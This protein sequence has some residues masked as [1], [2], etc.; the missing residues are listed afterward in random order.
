MSQR[1]EWAEGET[2]PRD[3]PLTDGNSPFDLTSA[4]SLTLLLT[5]AA[6]DVAV[7]SPGT[8]AVE[9]DPEDGIVRVTPGAGKLLGMGAVLLL[10]TD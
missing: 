7:A 5:V 9:G 2:A 6:S 10:V 1:I 8:V 4:T 3:F